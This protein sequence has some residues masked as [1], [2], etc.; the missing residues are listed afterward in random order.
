MLHEWKLYCIL[1]L[2]YFPL[3][4]EEDLGTAAVREVKEETGIEAEFVSLVAFRHVHNATFDCSDMYFIVHM[5]P[6][7]SQ[8][9]MCDKELAACEWMKVGH[10]CCLLKVKGYINNIYIVLKA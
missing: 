3:S 5:R 4:P 8:I 1:P 6:I 7:T 9:V 10:S 2:T